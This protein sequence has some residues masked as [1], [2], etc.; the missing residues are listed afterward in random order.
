MRVTEFT[1]YRQVVHAWMAELPNVRTQG[2]LKRRTGRASATISMILQGKRTLQPDDAEN[3]GNAMRLE[4]DDL[5]HFVDLVRMAHGKEQERHEAW[6]RVIARQTFARRTPLP[7]DHEVFARSSTWALL[8]LVDCAG[9]RPDP[10]WIA[11]TLIP[12]ITPA[13][14]AEA[15]EQLVTAGLLTRDDAGTLTKSDDPIAIADEEVEVDRW[16]ALHV[17]QLEHALAA[18][19]GPPED[20]HVVGVVFAVAEERL[21]DVVARLEAAIREV[22]VVEEDQP[23]DR[24]VQISLQIVPRS[25]RMK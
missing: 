8:A 6:E 17:E 11:E 15:L 1:D 18:L 20:R 23:P 4:G 2:L 9:F 24:V 13:E 10:Q 5:D 16:N 14:A 12:P 22:L 7:L 19:R 3:W 21:D 25:K